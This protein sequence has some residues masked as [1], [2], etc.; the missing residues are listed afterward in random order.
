VFTSYRN[1]RIALAMHGSAQHGS[2]VPLEKLLQ[3]MHFE[4][5]GLF[6]VLLVLARPTMILPV[7][8]TELF[9][10]VERVKSKAPRAAF[11]FLSETRA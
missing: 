5:L 6:F 2:A 4:T 9:G 7:S 8:V 11:Q 1:G 10:D 3:R